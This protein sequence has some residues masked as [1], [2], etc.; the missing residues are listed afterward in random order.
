MRSP[1]W[2]FVT[3]AL[4]RRSCLPFLVLREQLRVF[5]CLSFAK[6]PDSIIGVLWFDLGITNTASFAAFPIDQ[7]NLQSNISFNCIDNFRW[8]PGPSISNK[9]IKSPL[10]PLS[11]DP[12][13]TMHCSVCLLHSRLEC[14]VAENMNLSVCIRLPVPIHWPL[15]RCTDSRVD[16]MSTGHSGLLP[17]GCARNH[18]RMH[19]FSVDWAPVDEAT[20]PPAPPLVDVIFTI[21]AMLSTQNK[22]AEI[23]VNGQLL[24]LHFIY[25]HEERMLI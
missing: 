23:A 12:F 8:I 13:T 11:I 4:V 9:Y 19:W 2:V 21:F 14:L 20:D 22:C 6:D 18:H 17:V 3:A 7:S 1:F 25:Y 16:G 10:G 5:V 24:P 15:V